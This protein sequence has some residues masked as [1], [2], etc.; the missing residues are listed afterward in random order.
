M[1]ILIFSWR[2]PKHPHAGGAEIVTH[3][4]AKA[5][6]KAGHKVSLFTSYFPGAKSQEI[7]DGVNI[8]RKGGQIIS[9]QFWAFIWYLFQN[10]ED[11]DL[12]IDQFHGIPFFTPLFV[13]TKKLAFIHEVTKEVWKYNPLPQPLQTLV[14]KI[15][16]FCE[17]YIFKLF[18]LKIPFMTVSDSTKN[19]LAEIGI[20]KQNITVI[21]N[22][23]MGPKKSIQFKK[24]K[25]TITFIGALA[26]DKGIEDALIV[27][28]KLS[29]QN[30][31]FR[32]WVIGKHDDE[33]I[34]YLKALTA[35]LGLTKKV[36]FWGFV[37]ESKKFELLGK[38]YLVINP[39]VREGWGLTV[40]EA[41][42]MGVPTVA[43]NVA[44]LKD[45]IIN[46]KTGLLTK[47][48]RP[49]ML[50]DLVL[51]LLRNNKKYQTLSKG[52]RSWSSKFKWEIS[53]KK[54]RLLIEKI[55]RPLV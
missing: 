38:S 17:P 53:T 27:F 42:L 30:S 9:V 1:K 22:G 15:G 55:T 26:R 33:Y 40:M 8:I 54:S 32:F 2:G 4:H 16:A 44:G 41:G 11:F 21:H 6:I 10:K 50:S 29:K 24:D 12:V 28:S 34:V 19:E 31:D 51:E 35:E 43:Y 23:I 3:E 18:Y 52:V 49:E 45:T 20:S 39:S 5:W 25:N 47:I 48:N 46:G 36:K 13:K 37:S 7:I 14:G